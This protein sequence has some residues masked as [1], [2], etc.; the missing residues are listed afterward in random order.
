MF[1][2]IIQYWK[3]ADSNTTCWL[4]GRYSPTVCGVHIIHRYSQRPLLMGWK[5]KENT[6]TPNH[7]HS[8]QT[9][10]YTHFKNSSLSGMYSFFSKQC[11]QS[12]LYIKAKGFQDGSCTC[13]GYNGIRSSERRRTSVHILIFITK[14][15][16]SLIG[17]TK[18]WCVYI[19]QWQNRQGEEKKVGYWNKDHTL[20]NFNFISRLTYFLFNANYSTS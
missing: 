9:A 20:V 17:G 4:P 7:E 2:Y 19:L 11:L 10:A 8:N 18:W 14:I 5:L 16:V 1:T 3:W 12:F 13:W 6:A 15:H